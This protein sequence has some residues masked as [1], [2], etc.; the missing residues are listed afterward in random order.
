MI[1]SR[2]ILHSTKEEIQERTV[3]SVLTLLEAFYSSSNPFYTYY[4]DFHFNSK[5]G[6]PSARN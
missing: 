3:P 4:E 2:V 6:I 5:K 1:P